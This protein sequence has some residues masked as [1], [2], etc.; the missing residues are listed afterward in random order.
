MQKRLQQF[1]DIALDTFGLSKI[2]DGQLIDHLNAL[3]HL[4]KELR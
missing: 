1:T 3:E 2:E 4:E